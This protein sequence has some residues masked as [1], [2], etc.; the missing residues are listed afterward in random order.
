MVKNV[1]EPLT[2]PPPRRPRPRGLYASLRPITTTFLAQ[3][4]QD[5]ATGEVDVFNLFFNYRI[6]L[7][8]ASV[9]HVELVGGR[10]GE[11]GRSV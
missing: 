10:G 9:Q 5:V 3:P 1:A 2:S 8:L 6:S 11:R 7:L 4:E